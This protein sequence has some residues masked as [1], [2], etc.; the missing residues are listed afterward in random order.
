MMAITGAIKLIDFGLCADFSDG[1]RVSMV[2]SPFWVP[3]EMIKKEPHS[4]PADIWSL[5]VCILELYLM[6]PPYAQSGVQCM[7]MA[8]TQGLADQIPEIATTNAK[9][10]LLRCLEADPTKR[11]TPIELLEHPWISKSGL[12]KG[13]EEV[14]RD[15]FLTNT[16]SSLGF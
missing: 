6:V 4:F 13:I 3:P 2:G 15:I 7:F 16:L 8:A 9:N 1:P 10:F 11:A 14:L 5:G 12:S